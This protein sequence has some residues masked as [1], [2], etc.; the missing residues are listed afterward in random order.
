[1]KLGTSP[2]IRLMCECNHLISSFTNLSSHEGNPSKQKQT[3][4]TMNTQKQE[5]PGGI[6]TPPVPFTSTTPPS[7]KLINCPSQDNQSTLHE[8]RVVINVNIPSDLPGTPPKNRK[9]K[10][11]NISDVLGL[12]VPRVKYGKKTKVGDHSV[13]LVG[14]TDDLAVLATDVTGWRSG[15]DIL[16]AMFNTF[17]TEPAGFVWDAQLHHFVAQTDVQLMQTADRAMVYATPN[18]TVSVEAPPYRNVDYT[19]VVWRQAQQQGTADL[20]S[21]KS[22]SAAN[23]AINP[24]E[25]NQKIGSLLPWVRPLVE[26]IAFVA[27]DG[28]G[29]YN[30]AS[31]YMKGISLLLTHNRMA[32]SQIPI[33]QP[34]LHQAPVAFL[35]IESVQNWQPQFEVI[36]AACEAGDFI[37]VEGHDW[38]RAD[39]INLCYLALGGSP[40]AVVAQDHAI[41]TQSLRWPRIRFLVLTLSPPP[42]VPQQA[43]L[44]E[45][46]FMVFLRGLALSRSEESDLAQGWYDASF[47]QGS[48][49][50]TNLPLQFPGAQQPNLP[51]FHGPNDGGQQNHMNDNDDGEIA[52]QQ[53]HLPPLHHPDPLRRA[54]DDL[55]R[56]M[57]AFRAAYGHWAEQQRRDFDRRVLQQRQQGGHGGGGRGA[58]AAPQELQPP[59]LT[60]EAYIAAGHP[61]PVLIP[62]PDGSVRGEPLN[63]I[64]PPPVPGG[65][66]RPPAPVGPVNYNARGYAEWRVRHSRYRLLTPFWECN[67]RLEYARPQD[68]NFALRLAGFV[69]KNLC[70]ANVFPLRTCPIMTTANRVIMFTRLA[71][72]FGAILFSAGTAV[73]WGYNMTGQTLQ[74]VSAHNNINRY[75]GD[76]AYTSGLLRRNATSGFEGHPLLMAIIGNWV[77]QQLGCIVSPWLFGMRSWACN[78]TVAAQPAAQWL[79]AAHPTH[80]PR[81]G[82][83]LALLRWYRQ[84]PREWCLS[85]PGVN[86]DFTREFI[87][88]DGPADIRGW[89][90]ESA[91]ERYTAYPKSENPYLAIEYGA[92]AYNIMMQMVPMP[93]IM[94]VFQ[95]RTEVVQRQVPN[96][97]IAAPAPYP[98]GRGAPIFNQ[99]L[100]CIEPCT[101]LSY[102]WHTN[103]MMIPWLPQDYWPDGIA[104]W[105][106]RLSGPITGVGIT[107]GSTICAPQLAPTGGRLPG[108][109]GA[110][111]LERRDGVHNRDGDMAAARAQQDI[112]GLRQPPVDAAVNPPNPIPPNLAQPPDGA[113]QMNPPHNDVAGN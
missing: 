98:G 87:V 70:T 80:P 27:N 61:E 30:N 74:H 7:G 99:A 19:R 65:R 18:M 63:D 20:T 102:D 109:L 78:D 39:V 76:I 69:A 54:E 40:F 22:S 34:D 59:N 25:L 42:L 36:R 83:Q 95:Q 93:L 1:M 53:A 8:R 47:L 2:L 79:A 106:A 28:R 38:T 57:A 110:L 24:R 50:I 81:N 10:H 71:H 3:N 104:V 33:P 13:T 73:T 49:W 67:A 41:P 75:F 55:H 15:P 23:D 92:S 44:D 60:Y 51:D 94:P 84:I 101:L 32:M 96:L 56:A 6:R 112:N 62:P 4:L 88:W 103:T 58:A 91:D 26:A 85:A 86:V 72:W 111:A 97:P 21:L 17:H 37:L 113:V 16:G 31:M 43:P 5:H 68:T 77:K 64:I 90:A 11:A 52:M 107:W 82:T 66:A 100:R 108:M 29:I 105:L 9:R 14:V 12:D 46:G 35:Q 48:E 89:Y 45:E